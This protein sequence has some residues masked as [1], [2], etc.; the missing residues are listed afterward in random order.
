MGKFLTSIRVDVDYTLNFGFD[1]FIVDTSNGDINITVPE[2]TQSDLGREFFMKND[3]PNNVNITFSGSDTIDG[4]AT[5]DLPSMS[6]CNAL[7]AQGDTADTIGSYKWYVLHFTDPA[8]SGGGNVYQF[9]K[10]YNNTVTTSGAATLYFGNGTHSTIETYVAAPFGIN[11]RLK[12]A[13]CY[14]DIAP[15][16]TGTRTFTL[17]KNGV[18]TDILGVLGF[19]N[20]SVTTAFDIPILGTD[21]ISIRMASNSGAAASNCT[22]C[23]CVFEVS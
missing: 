21:I 15:G 5:Y 22:S 17:M 12:S 9:V 3:G 16:F 2:A 20:K 8:S 11:A 19:Y 13:T 4:S 6:C 1:I 14:V 7:Y 23:V 10:E 18:A